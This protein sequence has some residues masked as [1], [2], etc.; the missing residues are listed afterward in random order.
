MSLYSIKH[1]LT[2]MYVSKDVVLGFDSLLYLPQEVHT[3]RALVGGAEVTVTDGRAM[4]DK[5]VDTFWN[6]PPHLP[7]GIST[8]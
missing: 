7:A 3:P 1:G 2:F 8:W 5:N 6:L 4:G